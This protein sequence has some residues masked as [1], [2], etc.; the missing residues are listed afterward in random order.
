MKKSVHFGKPNGYLKNI[1]TVTTGFRPHEHTKLTHV[2]ENIWQVLLRMY[3]YMY[4]HPIRCL[5]LN[6]TLSVTVVFIH[7]IFVVTIF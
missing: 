3:L 5:S 1:S 6:I 4:Q 7:T 2:E